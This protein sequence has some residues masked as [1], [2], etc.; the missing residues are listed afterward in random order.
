MND[1]TSGIQLGTQD[2]AAVDQLCKRASTLED[3][4][5]RFGGTVTYTD[6]MNEAMRLRNRAYTIL[7]EAMARYAEKN[8]LNPHTDWRIGSGAAA[9][10]GPA[11]VDAAQRLET[12]FSEDR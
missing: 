7:T 8:I 1:M 12:F 4:A 2:Q 10:G 6:I 3:L 5:E 11:E 9:A